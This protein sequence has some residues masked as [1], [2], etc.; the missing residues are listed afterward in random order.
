MGLLRLLTTPASDTATP[1]G[2]AGDPQH[3]APQMWEELDEQI[4]SMNT[5][6]NV[7]P[8]SMRRSS[9]RGQDELA[10]NSTKSA[11]YMLI[12]PPL[13]GP[14]WA[15]KMAETR[16]GWGDAVQETVA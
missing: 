7:K 15:D 13:T 9:A 14:A 2:D 6:F 16:E 11:A 1:G 3:G 4:W 5:P 8:R 10:G 12:Q